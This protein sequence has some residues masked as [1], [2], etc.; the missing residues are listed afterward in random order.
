M[1]I[2]NYPKKVKIV[3]DYLEKNEYINILQAQR[4]NIAGSTLAG[5]IFRLRKEGYV[6]DSLPHENASF[7]NYRLIEIPEEHPRDE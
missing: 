3:R 6:I 2:P 4:M 1:A 7:V 5:C